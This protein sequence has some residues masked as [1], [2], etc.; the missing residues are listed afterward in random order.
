[1]ALKETGCSGAMLLALFV[2]CDDSSPEPALFP[3]NFE[4]TY[5]FVR[6]CR[7]SIDHGGKSMTVWASPEGAAAYRAGTY[8]LPVATVLVKK[9]HND[10]ACKELDGFVAMKKDATNAWVW[11]E[12]DAKGKVIGPDKPGKCITCH[13]TCTEGRDSTCTDP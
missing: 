4:S 12:T 3:S 8:P 5:T 2:A 13:D 6:D 7:L 1:M 11:Q 9:L 10:G